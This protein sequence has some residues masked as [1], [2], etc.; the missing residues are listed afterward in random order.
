MLSEINNE[1][2]EKAIKDFLNIEEF[3]IQ[4]KNTALQKEYAETY[5]DFQ[6]HIYFPEKFVN[7]MLENKFVYHFYTEE[8]IKNLK[9]KWLKNT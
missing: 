4:A 9:K 1:I 2:K 3:S 7:N 8:M 6:Q 5:K